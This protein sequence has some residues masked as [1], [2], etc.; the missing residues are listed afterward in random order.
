V[1]E[2]T[3]AQDYLK[4]MDWDTETMIPTESK[5]KELGLEDMRM[6]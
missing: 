5:L 2:K 6:L 3:M 4:A 1:D